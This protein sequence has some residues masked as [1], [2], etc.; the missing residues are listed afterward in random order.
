MRHSVSKLKG[1]NTTYNVVFALSIIF[2][3]QDTCGV[4]NLRENSAVPGENNQ[5]IVYPTFTTH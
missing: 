4:E 1:T 3:L 5:G 2:L